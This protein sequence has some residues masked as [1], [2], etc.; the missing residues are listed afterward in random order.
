MYECNIDRVQQAI[1]ANTCQNGAAVRAG[2]QSGIARNTRSI[3][4]LSHAACMRTQRRRSTIMHYC[5]EVRH[6]GTLHAG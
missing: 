1:S 3:L 4:H 5:T 6:A 2:I